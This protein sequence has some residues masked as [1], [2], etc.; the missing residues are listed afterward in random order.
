MLPCSFRFEKL[1]LEEQRQRKAQQS[2]IIE[3]RVRQGTNRSGIIPPPNLMLG[4]KESEDQ[5]S[6]NRKRRFVSPGHIGLNQREV[7][8]EL[9][10]MKIVGHH[11]VSGD[12]IID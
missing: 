10:N 3:A 6:S 5:F 9:S 12:H 11:S 8:L 1:Y 4:S 7:Q 2:Q